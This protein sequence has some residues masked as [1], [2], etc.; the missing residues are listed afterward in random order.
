MGPADEEEVPGRERLIELGLEVHDLFIA[1]PTPVVVSRN[2]I[3][4]GNQAYVPTVFGLAM[5]TIHTGKAALELQQDGRPLIAMPLVRLAFETAINV[6][7]LVH[8][9]QGL[10][11]FVNEGNRQRRALLRPC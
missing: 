2:K 5:H 3:P 10:W 1:T 7:W 6:Q 9:E 8:S 4:G 11:G